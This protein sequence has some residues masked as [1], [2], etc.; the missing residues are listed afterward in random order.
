MGK[1]DFNGLSQ[2]TGRI[3]GLVFKVVN[4]KQIIPPAMTGF[5]GIP[6]RKCRSCQDTINCEKQPAPTQPHENSDRRRESGEK[7]APK[8][9]NWSIELLNKKHNPLISKSN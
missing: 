3:V 7:H 1:T 4:G 5:G 8:F 9:N 2:W 6:T